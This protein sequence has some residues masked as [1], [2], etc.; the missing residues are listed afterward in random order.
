[1]FLCSCQPKTKGLFLCDNNAHGE[2]SAMVA[3]LLSYSELACI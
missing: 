1:M 2:S 3:M